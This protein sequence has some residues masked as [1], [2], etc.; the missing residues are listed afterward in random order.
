MT[1]SENPRLITAH[2]VVFNDGKF[3][4]E[5]YSFGTY[6]LYFKNVDD[7]AC[8]RDDLFDDLSDAMESCL[9]EYGIPLDSWE[10]LEA[11]SP[12][13]APLDPSI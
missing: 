6:C 8:I 9:D 12:I 4:L 1:L 3:I 2:S 11:H 7:A 10:L 5:T 13:M